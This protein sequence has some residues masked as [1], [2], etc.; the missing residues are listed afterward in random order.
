MR[1]P[2]EEPVGQ[3]DR[4]Q[5]RRDGLGAAR[6]G[7]VRL[8]EPQRLVHQPGHGHPRV[9]RGERVLEDDLHPPPQRPQVAA[10]GPV[11][12]DPFQRDLAG[13]GPEQAEHGTGERRLPAAGLADDGVRLAGRDA[14]ADAVHRAV[15]AVRNDQVL[16]AQ[17]SGDAGDVKGVGGVGGVGDHAATSGSAK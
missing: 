3:A 2:P 9:E 5:Q 6:R 1:P 12:P 10:P 8:R 16:H 7:Q 11:E 17:D 14:E 15:P 4:R 13:R